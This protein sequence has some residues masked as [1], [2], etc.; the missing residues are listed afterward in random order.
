MLPRHL[1]IIFEIVDGGL[2]PRLFGGG[3]ILD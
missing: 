2:D 3:S 1:E